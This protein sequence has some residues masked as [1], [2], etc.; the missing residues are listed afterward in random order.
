MAV[1]SSIILQQVFVT[2]ERDA[3]AGDSFPQSCRSEQLQLSF[4]LLVEPGR[5]LFQVVVGVSG[6][7]HEFAETIL[8]VGKDLLQRVQIK[9]AGLSDSIKAI[10]RSKSRLS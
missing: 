3:G 4:T 7:A 8:E 6:M 10:G 2:G 9:K 5:C 1:V